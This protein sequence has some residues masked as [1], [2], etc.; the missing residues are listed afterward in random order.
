MNIEELGKIRMNIYVIVNSDKTCFENI[1]KIIDNAGIYANQIIVLTNC[2]YRYPGHTQSHVRDLQFQYFL[3]ALYLFDDQKLYLDIVKNKQDTNYISFIDDDDF[4]DIGAREDILQLQS[5][6]YI[7]FRPTYYLKGKKLSYIQDSVYNNSTSIVIK[8]NLINFEI[9]K[10]FKASGDFWLYIATDFATI[11]DYTITTHQNPEVKVNLKPFSDDLPLYSEYFAKR[12]KMRYSDINMA[13]IMFPGMR[14]IRMAEKDAL[15]LKEIL[16]IKFQTNKNSFR[17]YFA[18]CKDIINLFLNFSSYIDLIFVLAH[19][20][21]G[22]EWFA[23]HNFE[24]I[25]RGVVK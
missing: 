20:R 16:K 11:I 2:G 9:L 10:D 23:K 1:T 6:D 7:H 24:D 12:L 15:V 21:K 19:H 5:M 14:R 8:Y 25:N 22:A 4:I 13:N 3:A 18:A 17:D